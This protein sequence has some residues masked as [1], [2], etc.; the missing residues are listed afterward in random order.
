MLIPILS[1]CVFFYIRA[2]LP[3]TS[4][5]F[6]EGG[7]GKLRVS[8]D[9]GLEKESMF[10]SYPR[11]KEILPLLAHSCCWA[12]NDILR[13]S[14]CGRKLWAFDE[15]VGLDWIVLLHHFS[16]SSLDA[17]SML[18]LTSITIRFPE[19]CNRNHGTISN[20][21][22]LEWLPVAIIIGQSQVLSWLRQSCPSLMK[23]KSRH[24]I[25]KTKMITLVCMLICVN[26]FEG[27]VVGAEW[28]QESAQP[29]SMM[30]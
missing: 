11:R 14:K 22:V 23:S 17:I 24:V 9:H 10:C 12:M 1:C 5:L 28:C 8:M 16:S 26:I 29:K 2:L 15:V 7:R 21:S 20:W 18:A 19:I 13:W 3:L 27:E 25:Y 30:M 4:P 6:L